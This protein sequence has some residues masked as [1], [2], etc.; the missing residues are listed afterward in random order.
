MLQSAAE[1][2]PPLLNGT[3]AL[4][5]EDQEKLGRNLLTT[6]VRDVARL[7]EVGEAV[8]RR[9]ALGEGIR[10]SSAK[11]LDAYLRGLDDGRQLRRRGAR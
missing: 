10:R 1:S 9:A 11:A 4:S 8:V 3:V 2:A 6:K 7:A 5:V